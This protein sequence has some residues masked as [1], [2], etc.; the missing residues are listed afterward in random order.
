MTSKTV[1]NLVLK[2]AGVYLWLQLG[3]GWLLAPNA[4]VSRHATLVRC[5]AVTQ[6]QPNFVEKSVLGYTYIP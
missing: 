5:V 6:T 4:F 1:P 2:F 3:L